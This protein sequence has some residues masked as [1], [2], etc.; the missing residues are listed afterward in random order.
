[1]KNS[2]MFFALLLSS[3]C[4]SPVFA[5]KV[6]QWKGGAPG[7]ETAWDCAQNWVGGSVPN[8]FSNVVIGDVSTASRAFPV[9][10]DG[11]VSVNALFLDGNA[12]LNIR[13][14]AQLVIFGNCVIVN[15][16]S[17]FAEGFF[18][19]LDEGGSK[20]RTDIAGM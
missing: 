5:Q 16:K 4:F 12:T 2:K 9:I 13:K 15:E 10:S 17:I 19:V 8:A 6:A 7:R 1:M 3:L 11:K 20:A 18:Q 14:G